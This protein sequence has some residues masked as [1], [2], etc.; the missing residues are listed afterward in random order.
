MAITG[1]TAT[2]RSKSGNSRYPVNGIYSNNSEK[3]I[4]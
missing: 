3:E 4:N 1:K 2:T